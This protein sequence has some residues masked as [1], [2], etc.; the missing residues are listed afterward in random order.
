MTTADVD[1]TPATAG[2]AG[3]AGAGFRVPAPR[4]P[5]PR[6]TWDPDEPGMRRRGVRP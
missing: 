3:T 4:G 2:S 1:H 6:E 5:H